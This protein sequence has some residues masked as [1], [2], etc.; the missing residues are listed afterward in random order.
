MKILKKI[1]I[2]CLLTFATISV[3][4]ARFR[5]NP[6]RAAAAGVAARLLRVLH[7]LRVSVDNTAH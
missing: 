4:D 3:A 5:R 6:P 2:F 1:A 7:D